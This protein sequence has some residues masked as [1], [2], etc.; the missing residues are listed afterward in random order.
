M[1]AIT[2]LLHLSG[3]PKTRSEIVTELQEIPIGSIYRKIIKL[4]KYGLI[5]PI[6]LLRHKRRKRNNIVYE[7]ASR[8]FVI[9]DRGKSFR[10]SI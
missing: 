1:Q 8:N 10:M 6:I 5:K 7:T 4:E 2:I 3:N 9:S